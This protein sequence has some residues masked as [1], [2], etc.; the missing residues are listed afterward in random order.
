MS[1]LTVQLGGTLQ[2]YAGGRKTFQVEAGKIPGM[3]NPPGGQGPAL[4]GVLD[5]GVA[6]AVDGQIIRE[7]WFHPLK[8]ENEIFLLPK[9]A[10]G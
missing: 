10:G 4:E 2:S 9:L 6:V 3:V 8:A 5:R 7:A 1:L